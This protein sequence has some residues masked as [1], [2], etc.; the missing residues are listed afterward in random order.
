MFHHCNQHYHYHHTIFKVNWKKS[1]IPIKRCTE[2]DFCNLSDLDHRLNIFH[3]YICY[4]S[5]VYFEIMFLLYLSKKL[6]NNR[7]KHNIWWCQIQMSSAACLWD[8]AAYDHWPKEGGSHV[9]THVETHVGL[10]AKCIITLWPKK[11][12]KNL[13]LEY[14][15]ES[16]PMFYRIWL[17]RTCSHHF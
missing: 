1:N 4:M 6:D 10:D 3:I 9:G 5:A 11:G 7:W 16:C 15:W 13:P 17:C 2:T 8:I 14:I 12:L